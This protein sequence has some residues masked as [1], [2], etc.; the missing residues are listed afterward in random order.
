MET[1]DLCIG[2]VSEIRD[3]LIEIIYPGR[4]I[5]LHAYSSTTLLD[6]LLFSFWAAFRQRSSFII[7]NVVI[8]RH[9]YRAL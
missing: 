6:R 3:K 8:R 4:S 1:F 9:V 7:D 5:E 2:L